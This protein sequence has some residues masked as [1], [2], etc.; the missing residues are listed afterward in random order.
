V[1]PWLRPLLRGVPLAVVFA[2]ATWPVV[3]WLVH[4]RDPL[5]AVELAAAAAAALRTAGGFVLLTTAA[6]CL[7]FPPA[8]AGLRL[9][10]SQLLQAVTSDPAPLRRAL[11]ELAHF[12]TAAR[13]AEIGRLLLL[14]GRGQLAAA[15]LQRALELD[16]SLAAAWHG[17]GRVMF[18]Q[19]AWQQAAA[20]FGNA[21]RL[22]PGHAFGEALLLHGRAR[23]CLGDTAALDVLQQHQQRH[24]GNSRSE[25]WLAEALDRAGQHDLATAALRRAAAA[26]GRRETAVE[27]WCRARARTRLFG[28]GGKR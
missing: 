19:H 2:A 7:L 23:H 1:A 27:Q 9:L 24:G 25:L 11:A 17:L 4:Q 15:H 5:A 28:R 21:E 12:E 6:L 16:P 8:L 22:D 14:R 18:G 3:L 20:A 26:P 10:G 13:H